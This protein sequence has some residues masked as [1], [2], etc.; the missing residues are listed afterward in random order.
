MFDHRKYKKAD[1]YEL[2]N[3][4]NPKNGHFFYLPSFDG[5]EL[6]VGL[7]VQKSN[8]KKAKGTILL[9]QGHNEFI[10][11]YFEVIQEFLDREFNVICFDWRGQGLSQRLNRDKNKSFIKSFQSHDQDI[12][13]LMNTIIKPFLEK[14]LIGVGHSMGGCLMLSALFNHKNEF[15]YAILSAP[16]LGFK[17][18]FLLKTLAAFT[19]I[20][21]KDDDY[22]IGSKPNMGIETDFPENELTSDPKRYERTLKL[23][24]KN[25]DLRLWG[26]T[27]AFV[28]SVIDRFKIMRKSHWAGEINTKILVFNSLEDKVVDARKTT[29]LLKNN[30]NIKI[31]NLTNIKHEIFMEK[32]SER[33]RLWSIIDDFLKI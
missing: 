20:I 5:V 7:W 17:Y 14:P 16:M 23:V 27:N 31:I 2:E 4:K 25:P 13:F 9:Q 3:F 11:K 19:N 21:F 8:N 30:K 22:F 10:E 12:K 28:K 15:D 33:S 24:R 18:E 1:F 26:T 29:K 32:D 6:R